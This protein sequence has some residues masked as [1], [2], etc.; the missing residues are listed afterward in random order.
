MAF[1]QTE[2]LAWFRSERIGVFP[3]DYFETLFDNA[4]IIG[5]ALGDGGVLCTSTGF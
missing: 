5:R 1:A 2:L 4:E 3:Q